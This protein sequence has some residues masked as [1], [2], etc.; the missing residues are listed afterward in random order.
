MWDVNQETITDTQS[1]YKSR[2]LNGFNHICAQQKLLMKQNRANKSSSSRRETKGFCESVQDLLADGKT[3]CERQF[4]EPFAGPV[5]PFLVQWSNV[6]R[7]LHETS[8]G[9]TNLARKF[10][11]E[12]SSDMHKPRGEFG[13]ET[14]WSQTLRNWTTW[15]PLKSTPEGSMLKK[16]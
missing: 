13:K 6:I 2:Q 11:L 7:F 16:C 8:Q 5:I 1:W 10:Y 12:N 4:G 14:F 9:T 15:T 3:P